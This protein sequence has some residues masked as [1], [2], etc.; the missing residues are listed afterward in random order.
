MVL[1][2]LDNYDVGQ[3]GVFSQLLKITSKK[4]F[5]DELKNVHIKS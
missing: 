4:T 3:L 2:V 1:Y 5:D